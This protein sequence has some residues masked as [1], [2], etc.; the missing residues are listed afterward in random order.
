MPKPKVGFYDLT[1]CQ[2]CLLSV[3]FNE[4][5]I[6]DMLSKIDVKEFRFIMD[7]KYSGKLDV[8]FV[9]GTVV[10]KEDEKV[11]GKL[12][13][14]SKILVALGACAC[15]GNIPALRNFADE[16]K[17]DYL[18]YE[19]KHEQMQDMEK[20]MP[21]AKFVNVDYSIPG[22]PPDRDEI[23]KF[24]KE[25]LLG[26]EFR[27][28]SDPVCRECRLFENGCLIDDGQIC[29]GPLTKGGCHAVCTTNGFKCYGC[30]GV[31]DD[32]N[33]E[34]Y[35]RLLEEKGKTDVQIKKHMETFAGI[36]INEK[37]KDTEW[38]QLH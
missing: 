17:L 1:G 16:K 8:C 11:L 22:C 25:I 32:A 12:R 23:K 5:E 28:Y 27:N 2:G 38:Q 30:R 10:N 26:K 31:T 36:E 35:F 6:L 9:E 15:H 24:I 4:N 21:I 29:L 14:R 20:P 18:K 33:F 13:E 7:E 19:K 3:I 37:L 34:G